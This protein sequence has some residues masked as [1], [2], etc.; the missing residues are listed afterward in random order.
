MGIRTWAT[1]MRSRRPAV[2]AKINPVIG[3]IIGTRCDIVTFKSK[4]GHPS[5][6]SVKV[7]SCAAPTVAFVKMACPI[8]RIFPA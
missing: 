6:G 8:V 7:C 3:K 2:F 4:C 1:K 5:C